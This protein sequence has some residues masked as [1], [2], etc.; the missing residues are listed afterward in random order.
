MEM[1]PKCHTS[2]VEIGSVSGSEENNILKLRIVF[3]TQQSTKFV[4]HSAYR[5]FTPNSVSISFHSLCGFA[6][7]L[8]LLC[9]FD[10]SHSSYKFNR[11]NVHII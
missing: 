5:S 11:N 4:F 2:I 6:F 3:I 7:K 1:G 9:F 10:N 8:Y